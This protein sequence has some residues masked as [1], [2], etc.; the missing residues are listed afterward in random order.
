[1][2]DRI[3]KKIGKYAI[4]N[5]IYYVLGGYVIGYILLLM[6]S[7]FG[8][9]EYITLNPALVM[10]GQV[11]RLF[12]WV[13]TPPQNFS[14]FI[15]F[16]F[17]L[18]L[19]IG[20]SL[21]Q[22]LGAFKY[23]LYM[24]SGWFFMTLGAMVIYWITEAVNGPS[25]A[26]S[27]N[28]STYYLNLA[29]FLAFAVLFPDVR[30]YFFGVLP[31][32]I[33][34]I[35]IID[36]AYLGLQVVTS[37]I[38]LFLLPNPEYQSILVMVGWTKTNFVTEIFSV[39]ISLLNFIIFF[40][41]TRNFRRISPAE[42]RRQKEFEKK[43]KDGQNQN[44]SVGLD[45]IM[46]ESKQFDEEEDAENGTDEQPEQTQR[47]FGPYVGPTRSNNQNNTSDEF[48]DSDIFNEPPKRKF[49]YGTGAAGYSKPARQQ[50]K[51]PKP[52]P[53]YNNAGH[54]LLH[55]CSICGRTS[56]TNPELTFRYCSKCEGNH[57]Y[58]QDH[59]FTHVHIQ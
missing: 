8:L 52:A 6:D 36:I 28:V 43:V 29:S 55:T 30:V 17:L 48:D 16:M 58:C 38:S 24:F 12:T 35:A 26:I 46:R 59:L 34:W 56:E 42:I 3:E 33:K 44:P 37:V 15:I 4:K 50:T 41:A 20:K 14:F 27:M 10:K 2:L 45:A 23:N 25:G 13:C 49:G 5:L 21:E 1:M 7:R 47:H 22:N 54:G 19:W 39:L 40:I 31:I 53:K 51:E 9:Y 18:Y 32:R 11:W 57:E